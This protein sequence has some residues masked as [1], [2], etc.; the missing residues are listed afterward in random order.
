M[1]RVN[2]AG[3]TAHNRIVAPPSATDWPFDRRS[4]P[5]AHL[6]QRG[7]AVQTKRSRRPMAEQPISKPPAL[8]RVLHHPHRRS[9][10]AHAPTG[11]GSIALRWLLLHHHELGP[12]SCYYHL[13][14]RCDH[15][16]LLVITVVAIAGLDRDSGLS[17]KMGR[18]DKHARFSCSE[19]AILISKSMSMR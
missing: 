4:P 14:G 1:S 11:S 10:R 9:R 2:Q 18:A 12:M 16:V 6:R 5:V 7:G 3:T 15:H 17:G 8:P 19:S 13:L